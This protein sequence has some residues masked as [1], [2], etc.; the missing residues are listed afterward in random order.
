MIR[1][2]SDSLSSNSMC[3]KSRG[4]HAPRPC[5]VSLDTGIDSP[6][7]G[8]IDFQ[9]NTFHSANRVL[10]QVTTNT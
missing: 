8:L 1:N 9:P 3:Q 2:E 6:G 7:I 5:F 10:Y 4:A